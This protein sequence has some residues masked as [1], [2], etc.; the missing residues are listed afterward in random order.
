MTTVAL[1]QA[2]MG[3][4]R[5]PGKVLAEL[6]GR[7][8]L[9]WVVAAARAVPG[10]DRV[11]VATSDTDRDDPVAAW[12]ADNG[13]SCH[14]GPED[15]VLERFRGAAKAEEA[16][17]VMRL[18]A[19][20]PLL[21]PEV[22][23]QVLLLLERTG[24]DY[25]SN[26]DPPSWPDG[27]DCEAFTFAA[28]ETA[29]REARR[30]SE[31]EHVTTFIRHHRKLFRV[32]GL[33]CPLPALSRVRWA[34]DTPADLEFLRALTG[35]LGANGPPSHVEVLRLLDADP[36]LSELNAAL[37]RN[38]GYEKSLLAEDMVR[39]TAFAESARVL[40]RARNVI[41]LGAQTF[42]KSHIQFPEGH[43]PLFLTHG[44]RGRVWDA[45]GNE[46]VDLVCGLL[47]VVLGYRDQD[48]DD[49]I[50]EQ[51]MNG[52]SFSLATELEIELA[53]RLVEIIPCAEMVRFGKNGS[54]ATTGAV[55][56][57]RA[58]T[59]RDR[60][61]VCGYHG[62]HDWYIGSTTRNKGIPEAVQ[63]LTHSFPY[64]DIDALLRLFRRHPGEFAA[65]TIEP[66]NVVEPKPGYLE[67]LADLTRREG[68]VLIFDEIIT[69]FRYSLGGAQELFGVTPD[70]AA[71]GKAMGN[72][73]PISAVVGRADLM[74]EMEEIFFSSTFG[75]ETLSLAA[76]IAVID[77]MRREPVIETLW[78]T[79]E[80][81]A[82]GVRQRI[83]DHG[84][85]EV[86]T[87]NG[88][89]PWTVLGIAD[90]PAA[91]KEAVKT[92]LLTELIGR[93]VLMLGSHN[94]CYAHTE[95]DLAWVLAAYDEALGVVRREIEG[96]KLEA[97]LACPVIEPIFRV[98]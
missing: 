45:D 4:T 24:A 53:E 34:L 19:D 22:C 90:H 74:A 81:L 10:V 52:I 8:V 5:L 96:R 41:P 88:K 95:A 98:R 26:V 36:A 21:D 17:T 7:S 9:D 44:S 71:F 29:A 56:I 46:Y 78:R 28:L 93:G 82:A 97:N 38:D 86:I 91:R 11:A 37:S 40:A 89:A 12:C 51:L 65:V 60:I 73:M 70:L 66:M 32:V 47:P 54:D 27:L 55:R 1:I 80:T 20:A 33:G 57:A 92:L 25:A 18:T 31:R 48:V 67:E 49:A 39:T 64:N 63:E 2:R 61:A 58:A 35:R 76:A 94:I 85:E 15:D 16:D 69:G 62:W 84:L 42:S 87:V 79:G 83:A 13:V 14:R 68:A 23:G 72:G 50:R 75:G 6:A 3:S 30:P 77:K 59:G 43:A